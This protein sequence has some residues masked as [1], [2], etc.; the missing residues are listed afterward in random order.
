MAELDRQTKR[1]LGVHQQDGAG[2]VR[3]DQG[4][5]R[6]LSDP[7]S[8]HGNQTLHVEPWPGVLTTVIAPPSARTMP[9]AEA[10]PKPRPMNLV[11]KKGS[12]ILVLISSVMPQP[13]SETSSTT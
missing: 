9:C 1:V 12:K 3:K 7:L 4:I 8:E 13:L 11:E 2:P 6:S 5:P 10:S